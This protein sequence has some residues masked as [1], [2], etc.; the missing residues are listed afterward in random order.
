MHTLRWSVRHASLK[1]MLIA[2]LLRLLR[3]QSAVGLTR[4]VVAEPAVGTAQDVTLWHAAASGPTVISEPAVTPVDSACEQ[5]RHGAQRAWLWL[6]PL[7]VACAGGQSGNEGDLPPVP[8]GNGG[9]VISA[10]VSALSAGCVTLEVIEI[11]NAAPIL[12]HEGR[13][14]LAEDELRVGERLQGKRGRVYAYQHEFRIGEQVVALVDSWD[15]QLNFE[16]MP[17]QGERLQVQWAGRA[18]ETS[19]VEFA[20][21]CDVRRWTDLGRLPS[22]R[23]DGDDR[24]TAPP[25]ETVACT[26]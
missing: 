18:Y 1:A 2:R 20:L 8:C 23:S 22:S 3:P 17:M 13:E 6:A 7:L 21:E 26:P 11:F 9:V 12:D 10:E 24:L 4:A 16:L 15:T 19:L 14:L 25:P 5:L